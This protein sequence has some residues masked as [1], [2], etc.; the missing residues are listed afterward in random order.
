[1]EKKIIILILGIILLSGGFIFWLL[2]PLFPTKS[3]KGLQTNISEIKK[4]VALNTLP[5]EK[6]PYIILEPKS[7][8][9]PQSLGHW[10]TVTI[11]QVD[12]FERVEYE[13]EYTTGTMI[14]GGMG[15]IDFGKE[16]PPVSKEIAFGSASKGKYKYDEGVNKGQFIFHFLKAGEEAA[17]KTDFQLQT[18]AINGGIFRTN[19]DKARLEAGRSDL[20][21]NGYLIVASTLGLPKAPEGKMISG[22]YG[23]YA[24]SSHKLTN[25]LLIFKEVNQEKVAILRWDGQQWQEYETKAGN[26]EASAKVDSLGTFVLVEK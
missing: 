14:Q 11:D 6:R 24:D 25:S 16:P 3:K 26:S 1:M 15:R 5:T 10:V 12:D 9:E 4:T 20:K 2:N 8:V 22:P 18:K 23:F 13:F 21:N 19:D 17:L 7:S